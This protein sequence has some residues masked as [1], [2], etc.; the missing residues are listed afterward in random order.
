M[1][2]GTSSGV[3]SNWP[4]G[5]LISLA[6]FAISLFGPIPADEVSFVLLKDHVANHL[7]ERTGGTGMRSDIQIRFIE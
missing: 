2:S 5:F 6:I 7:R 1:K 4:L 3:T